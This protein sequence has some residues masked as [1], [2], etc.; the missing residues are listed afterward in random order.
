[1]FTSYHNNGAVGRVQKEE[2]GEE[3]EEGRFFNLWFEF[4]EERG[5]PK[6]VRGKGGVETTIFSCRW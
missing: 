2:S 1:M 5:Q 6:R 3:G 4:C